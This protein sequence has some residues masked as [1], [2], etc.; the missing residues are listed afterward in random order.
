LETINWQP[1]TLENELI[2]LVPL[3][4]DNFE[5]LYAVAA[6][7]AIWAQHPTRDRYKREVFQI[8]FD[9]AVAAKTAFLIVDKIANKLIG[10]SRY[11]DYKP[12]DN[13]IAIGFT[14]LATDYWGGNYNKSL[15]K[16]MLDYAFQFVDSV[17]F[18][19]GAANIRSQKAVEKIGGKKIKEMDV[20]ATGQPNPH[21]E[22]ELKKEDYFL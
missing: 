12:A 1:E 2:K 9:S 22:Y 4:V 5:K 3:Q 20:D 17:M 13:S 16:L 8:F 6:D 15:K 7:P 14:F 10:S 21:V 19:I 18:H 11:Y